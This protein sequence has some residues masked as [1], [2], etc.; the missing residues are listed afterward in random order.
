MDPIVNLKDM[1]NAQEILERFL[2][3]GLPQ[4]DSSIELP[5][6]VAEILAGASL[7]LSNVPANPGKDAGDHFPLPELD[8]P[9]VPVSASIDWAVL[10]AK[11]KEEND[12][13]QAKIASSG[14]KKQQNEIEAMANERK[15]K[16]D[17]TLKKMDKAAKMNIFMKIFG[18]LMV[19]VSLVMAGVTCGMAGGLVVGALAGAAAAV[20]L[21]ALNEAGVMEKLTKAIADGLKKS[22]LKSPAADI[23]AAV[24]TALIEIGV[25]L[26]A[27]IGGGAAAASKINKLADKAMKMGMTSEQA[28]QAATKQTLLRVMR[29]AT[30][31]AQKL[32]GKL[33]HLP[34]I[35][36]GVEEGL[37]L[38]GYAVQPAAA[39]VNLDYGLA[40]AEVNKQ[41]GIDQ[42]RVKKLEEM[43]D[44][45]NEILMQLMN[46]PDVV[47]NLL[48]KTDEGKQA[49]AARTEQMA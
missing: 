7:K 44:A 27:S 14:V 39:K 20:T 46:S 11:I 38:I 37:K 48:I 24:F 33:K 23:L 9:E 49:I 25:A 30:E 18:W 26:C 19:G 29:H 6:A 42:T 31:G 21:Q 45:L 1:P 3:Q 4:E 12:K 43:I 2:A 10:A 40:N 15:A 22:G 36:K 5:A 32:T 16:I 28:W 17:D 34:V 8:E 13:Y 35:M 47:A 41:K